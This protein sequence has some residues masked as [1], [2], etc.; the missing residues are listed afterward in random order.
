[1]LLSLTC[2]IFVIIRVDVYFGHGSLS[3]TDQNFINNAKKKKKTEQNKNAVQNILMWYRLQWW[4]TRLEAMV[5]RDILG[6]YTSHSLVNKVF[7]GYYQIMHLRIQDSTNTMDLMFNEWT[8]WSRNS[9]YRKYIKLLSL[10][11]SL[12]SEEGVD[13]HTRGVDLCC[14]LNDA[15]LDDKRQVYKK[16]VREI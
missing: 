4:L 14:C 7:K 8:R 15:C 6:S 2:Q 1:M 16:V 10:A 9:V 11:Q 3:R 12:V 5:D 13:K